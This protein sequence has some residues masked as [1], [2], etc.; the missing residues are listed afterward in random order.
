MITIFGTPRPFKGHFEIIQRNAIASWT[1]L[2]PSPQILIMGNDEGTAEVCRDL[3]VTHVPDIECNEFGTP[4]VNSMFEKAETLSENNVL[5]AC[6]TDTLLFNDTLEAAR[7]ASKKFKRFCV[8]TGRQHIQQNDLIDFSKPGWEE[9]V[10]NRMTPTTPD[11]ITAGDYFL[12]SKGVWGGFPPFA[13]GRT[14][15]DNWMYYKV[16]ASRGALIDA[17][18]YL[19][20]IHQ[21]HDHSHHPD[22]VQ[23]VWMGIEAQRNQKLGGAF[24]SMFG[25]K[26]ANWILNFNELKRP[27][28]TIEN[29]DRWL[30]SQQALHPVLWR[31]LLKRF[32][33]VFRHFVI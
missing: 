21:D 6:T 28:I 5:L 2:R 33:W 23:G 18:A 20:T 22:G 30:G 1:Q 15:C 17:T 7:I 27:P 12:F 9:D 8:I 26:H 11:D 29:F 32:Q 31:L 19:T 14:V 3:G 4:L 13:I 10:C 25:R 24:A 16:L